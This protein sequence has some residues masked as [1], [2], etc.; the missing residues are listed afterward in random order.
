MISD[1]L[2]N[3]YIEIS[4]ADSLEEYQLK[5]SEYA[6]RL[7]AAGLLEI[8]HNIKELSIVQTNRFSKRAVQEN[9]EYSKRNILTY[10]DKISLKDQI[11]STG[12]AV[13]I[14]KSILENFHDYCR[15]LY[16]DRIHESC[17]NAMKK[18][19]PYIA[20]ENEYD[21]QRLMYSVLRAVRTEE[22]E[23]S[24]HHMIR[25]DIVIDSCNTVIELKCPGKSMTERRLSE[26]IAAD[27]V[28]YGNKYI[29][30]YIYD[31]ENVIKNVADFKNTYEK[32]RVDEKEI[33][34][35]IWKSNAI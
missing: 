3:A 6:S 18:H 16:K 7:E 21:L 5:V 35:Y 15:A 19:L 27:M 25:K 11:V 14:V 23:D 13:K 32:K 8:A 2:H 33:Y 1:I 17:G 26:E 30:F 12:N 24:G 10:L 34:I 9:L 4:A 28:H 20:I 31:K 29:F 22:T